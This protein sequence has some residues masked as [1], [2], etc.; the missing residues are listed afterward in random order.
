M[1][2]HIYKDIMVSKKTLL[3]TFLGFAFI[4]SWI[5]LIPVIDKQIINDFKAMPLIFNVMF[6]LM[7]AMT[8]Y[9]GGMIEDSFIL[10][11]ESKRWAYFVHSTEDGI[12]N[13]VGAKYILCLLF[14]MMTVFVCS[15][16]NGLHIDLIDK[17]LPNLQ[18]IIIVIFFFQLFMRAISYPFIFA[19]GSKMGNNI[20]AITFLVIVA[21]GLIFLLFGDISAIS[22]H[23]D[24]IWD[25]IFK[26]LTDI[27]SNWKLVLIQGIGCSAVCVLYYISYRI[28]CKVY[29]KGVE[30][31]E[32]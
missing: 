15:F 13:T 10:H 22:D 23:S 16:F 2:G 9:I 11:D 18:S 30:R 28:S 29:M 24:E 20:K 17:E 12:K 4:N 32:R 21:A 8:F 6:M 27:G 25:K 31:F 1:L 3:L 19:F 5:L 26:L 7:I 14:S